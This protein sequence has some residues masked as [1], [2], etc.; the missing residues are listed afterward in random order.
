[1]SRARNPF[2]P[3]A[4]LAMVTGGAAIF[5]LLLLAL[6]GGWTGRENRNGGAHAASI[7]LAGFAALADLL[8][9]QG[10]EV[11]LSRSRA[12]LDGQALLV[13]TPDHSTDPE[14]LQD[15]IDSRRHAGPTLLILPKWLA[16]P[17]PDNDPRIE[18]E[19]GWVALMN[20]MAPAWIGELAGL[21]DVEIATGASSGWSGLGLSGALPDEDR[22]QAITNPQETPLAP[23]VEDA[24]GDLLVGY[25]GTGGFHPALAGAAGERLAQA[26]ADQLDRGASPLVVVVEPDL[27]NNYGMAE[28]DRAQLAV[29]L[30][31][32]TLG[33]RDLPIIFDLTVP[34]LGASENLLTLAFRPPFLAATLCLILALIV[35]GWRAFRR[36]GPPLAEQPVIARGKGQLAANG[37]AL[38]E[39]A[40]RWHLLG[41]PYAAL[42][43]R[44]LAHKLALHQQTAQAREAALDRLIEQRGSQAPPFS[45]AAERLRDASRPAELLRA[46][47]ALRSIERTLTR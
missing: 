37:A 4:V 41:P 43:T 34:G 6:G 9:R 31:D 1:M 17:L 20:A 24:E 18:A 40:K 7:G 35:I 12:A 26:Q 10:R 23:L 33:G 2:H 30:V 16:S 29:A 21:D 36:F 19:E 14:D 13:I 28:L 47:G 5:L 3:A 11:S 22:V 38:V 39:R 32:A 8:Q 42:V 15:I 46:A 27:L 25:R 44:R 45:L